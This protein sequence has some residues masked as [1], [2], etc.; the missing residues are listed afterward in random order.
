MNAELA[1]YSE[2]GT[3]NIVVLEDGRPV[4]W[5]RAGGEPRLHK[6]D[7][8][9]GLVRQVTPAL[10]CAFVDIGDVHDAMLP[11]RDPRPAVK[12]GQPLLVQIRR[13]A[14]PGKGHQVSQNIQLPGPYAVFA[15]EGSAKRRSKLADFPESERETLFLT[16]L[17]RLRGVWQKVHQ[18]SA[19]GP[20]PRLLLAAGDPLTVALTSLVSARIQQIRV[21]GDALFGQVYEKIAALMPEYLPKLAIYVPAQ[22]YGLAAVLG[23][24]QTAVQ[25]AGRKVWLDNGG[26][27][28]IDRTEALTAIDVNSGKDVRGEDS[29]GLRLRTN[30]LAAEAVARQI[31]LRN[32]GGIFVIDFLK[33]QDTAEQEAVQARLAELTARDRAYCRLVGFTGLGL[34]EMTRTAQ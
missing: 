15:S 34:F 2:N 3:E 29:A 23:L 4:E 19:T 24:G 5:L 32:L 8:V 21:E 6:L 18:A 20:V 1:I 16:D 13:E 17:T 25:M 22:G 28:T 27:I 7:I 31:R 12:T 11:L 30:L 10:R 9:L 26:C 14:P 33:M